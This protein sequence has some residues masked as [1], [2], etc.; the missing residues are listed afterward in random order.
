MILLTTLLALQAAAGPVPAPPF[1]VGETLTYRGKFSFISAGSAEL[2]VV[3]ID[4]VRGVPSWHFSFTTEVS[5]PFYKN[6]SIFSSWTGLRDFVSRRF[7]KD[8]TEND[9]NRSEV[10][11]IL[12]DSGYYRRNDSPQTKPTSTRPLDDVAFFYWIRTVPL[13]IGKTYKFNNY[14]RSDQNPVTITVEKRE[15]K[16]LY[17]GSKVKVLLLRPIV[18]E[19]GGMFSRK[20]EAKLW[21]TDDAR[22]LPVEIET[23]LSIGNLKLILESVTP[24]RGG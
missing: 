17:D 13:E 2:K 21:L 22:R 20:S 16:K 12:P 4:T 10:F 1:S 6:R 14:F 18:D 7:T 23:N 9:K 8:V 19:E 15:T 5:V 24:G 11:R 3:G